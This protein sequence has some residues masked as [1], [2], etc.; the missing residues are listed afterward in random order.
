M[1]QTV[2][3]VLWGWNK[4]MWPKGSNRSKYIYMLPYGR[5]TL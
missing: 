4:F 2:E 5:A 1:L 3:D